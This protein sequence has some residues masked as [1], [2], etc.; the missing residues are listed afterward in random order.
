[1]NVLFARIYHDLTITAPP[2]LPA[3]GAA[4]LICNHTSGLDPLLLQSVCNRVVIWMMAKEYY[5]IRPLKPAFKLIEAIPVDRG[6]RD[7]AATRSALRALQDGRVLGIFPEGRIAPTGDLLPFQPGVALMAIKA[8]VPVYP[9]YL[10][11]TQRGLEIVQALTC[12]NRATLRFGPEVKF[13]RSSTSRDGL[14][15]ATAQ[16]QAAVAALRD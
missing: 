15:A 14:E 13:D 1:L 7:T 3:K 10:D 8:K 6:S 9:A 12:R 16:I 11:G 4:I 5:D 2:R